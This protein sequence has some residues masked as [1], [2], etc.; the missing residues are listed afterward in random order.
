[1]PGDPNAGLADELDW[2]AGG[3]AAGK[4][5]RRLKENAVRATLYQHGTTGR[6]ARASS[7]SDGSR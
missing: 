4:G 1:M 7:E 6:H 3:A 5:E 2:V